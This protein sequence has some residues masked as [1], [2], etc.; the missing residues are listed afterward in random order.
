MLCHRKACIFSNCL[1]FEYSRT[2]QINNLQIHHFTT[3]VAEY[4]SIG[5]KK[6]GMASDP[7]MNQIRV[8]R[9]IVF[10]QTKALN[11]RRIDRQI[12]TYCFAF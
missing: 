6:L 1:H 8:F 10:L 4:V 11:V 3:G 5:V 7:G 9:H 2:K 12:A